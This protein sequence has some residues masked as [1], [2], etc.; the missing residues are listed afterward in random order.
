M[1]ADILCD[2]N[3]ILPLTFFS[4]FCLF[5]MT[6]KSPFLP[7]PSLY[8]CLPSF[9]FS[10]SFRLLLLHLLSDSHSKR[11]SLFFSHLFLYFILFFTFP[12]SLFL[13]LAVCSFFVGNRFRSSRRSRRRR[14][15]EEKKVGKQDERRRKKGSEKEVFVSSSFLSQRFFTPNEGSFA[16]NFLFIHSLW[17]SSKLSFLF[18][19]LCTPPLFLCVSRMPLSLTLFLGLPCDLIPVWERR[20]VR[21][22]KGLRRRRPQNEE[23]K[24]RPGGGKQHEAQVLYL[25]QQE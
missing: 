20:R 8:V 11:V 19:S 13:F 16:P 1:Q 21:D 23:N 25:E 10:S 22:M 5:M 9:S 4:T 6:T 2:C 18:T 14:G 15:R 3:P 17:C 24:K 7:P 12:L